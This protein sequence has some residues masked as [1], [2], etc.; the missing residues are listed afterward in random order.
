MREL[1]RFCHD[2]TALEQKE[3]HVEDLLGPEDAIGI[4]RQGLELYKRM[5]LGQPP[6]P[7]SV[8]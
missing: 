2:Y 3:V 4:I 5:R 1:Q 7:N 8:P 6:T